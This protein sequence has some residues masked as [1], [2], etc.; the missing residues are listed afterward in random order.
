MK[1]GKK[2]AALRFGHRRL[3]RALRQWTIGVEGLKV[4]GVEGRGSRA[5]C[6]VCTLRR[7]LIACPGMRSADYGAGK[8]GR[9]VR[10]SLGNS[11][12][13]RESVRVRGNS[14]ESVRF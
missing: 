12:S 3:S 11:L 6:W 4:E 5:E 14:S 8:V 7:F 10:E 13:F 2:L 9:F 1:L